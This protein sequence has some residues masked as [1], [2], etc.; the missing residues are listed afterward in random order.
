M[1]CMYVC[2]AVCVCMNATLGYVCSFKFDMYAMYVFYVC[3]YV[4]CALRVGC[5][6]R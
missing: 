1:L 4:V 2:F 3:M 6:F 5:V